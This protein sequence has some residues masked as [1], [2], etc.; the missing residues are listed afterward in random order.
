MQQYCL[1]LLWQETVFQEHVQNTSNALHALLCCELHHSLQTFLQLCGCIS[2]VWPDS[3]RCECPLAD[4]PSKN[5]VSLLRTEPQ[6]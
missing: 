5:L 1:Q 2:R 4:G 6:Y 3:S